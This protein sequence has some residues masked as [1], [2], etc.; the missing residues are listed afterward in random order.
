MPVGV[1]VPCMHHRYGDRTFDFQDG[2]TNLATE[3]IQVADLI[4]AG[5][6]PVD[7]PVGKH[8]TQQIAGIGQTDDC[9]IPGVRHRFRQQDIGNAP[10]YFPFRAPINRRISPCVKDSREFFLL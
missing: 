2:A 1:S 10:L 7:L 9:N 4:N 8:L 3:E 6:Y 5:A